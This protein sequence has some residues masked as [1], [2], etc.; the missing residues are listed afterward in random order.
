MLDFPMYPNNVSPV[1]ILNMASEELFN[2]GR[3]NW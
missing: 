1:I 2:A 3:A